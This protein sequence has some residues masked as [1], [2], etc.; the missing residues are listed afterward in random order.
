MAPDSKA[1]SIVYLCATV[2]GDLLASTAD[3]LIMGILRT[4]TGLRLSEGHYL[5]LG[6]QGSL[7]CLW[8]RGFSQ[9]EVQTA[10]LSLS[11]GPVFQGSSVPVSLPLG[12]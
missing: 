2:W 3:F 7:C 12:A 11:L 1:L 6:W 8:G 10:L 4:R 5:F 9:V